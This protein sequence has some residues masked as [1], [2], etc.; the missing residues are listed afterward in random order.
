[1]SLWI[2]E[3]PA[4][5]T[6]VFIEMRVR[7]IGLAPRSEYAPQPQWAFPAQRGKWKGHHA[8]SGQ[9]HSC[10]LRALTLCDGQRAYGAPPRAVETRCYCAALALVDQSTWAAEASEIRTARARV[11]ARAA[12]VQ[13]IVE[14][15]QRLNSW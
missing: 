15:R 2:F 3:L 14:S 5:D 13:R 1:M 8:M 9:E 10:A 6:P 11:V 4:H 7:R 12:E